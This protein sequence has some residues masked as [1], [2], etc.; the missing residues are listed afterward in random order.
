MSHSFRRWQRILYT[1]CTNFN[2]WSW[3]EH[4][5]YNAAEHIVYNAAEHIVYNAE[6]KA[7]S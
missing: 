7:P 5:V 3:A 1:Y 4:I 6:H 2:E